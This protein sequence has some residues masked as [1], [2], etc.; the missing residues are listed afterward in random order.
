MTF[1]YFSSTPYYQT[2][3]YFCTVWDSWIEDR[4]EAEQCFEM[5]DWVLWKYIIMTFSVVLKECVRGRRRQ[6][7]ISSASPTPREEQL[8]LK[9]SSSPELS[10]HEV[11]LLFSHVVCLLSSSIPS[12]SSSLFTSYLLDGESQQ[13]PPAPGTERAAASYSSVFVW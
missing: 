2:D 3:L 6:A 7:I 1:S 10:L 12:W 9:A 11:I 4:T 5:L 8:T 13:P